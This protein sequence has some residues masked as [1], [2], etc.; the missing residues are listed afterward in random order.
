MYHM[1]LMFATQ[2]FFVFFPHA[3]FCRSALHG[4]FS[5]SRAGAS[6]YQPLDIII[7]S[8]NSCSLLLPWFQT[9]YGVWIPSND[10]IR[11]WEAGLTLGWC[12][13]MFCMS[14][15]DSAVMYF[16]D[17]IRP[18]KY[19]PSFGKLVRTANFTAVGTWNSSHSPPHEC[20]RCT[21]TDRLPL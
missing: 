16:F 19:W 20:I 10:N 21:S 17:L 14:T 4:V 11:T 5:S 7:Y 2:R 15:E 13:Y 1:S 12:R 9:L 18:P 6:T 3:L 8:N